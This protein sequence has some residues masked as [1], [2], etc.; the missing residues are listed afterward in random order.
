MA[1]DLHYYDGDCSTNETQT[2][3]KELFIKIINTSAFRQACQD[4]SFRD[5][6]KAENVVV[7]CGEVDE[8]VGNR[9]RRSTG[10]SWNSFS[11]ALL[12]FVLLY[13]VYLIIMHNNDEIVT[14]KGGLESLF[15]CTLLCQPYRKAKDHRGKLH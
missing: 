11:K 4:P 5:K 14:L 12:N 13:D 10:K 9:K 3:I 15:E 6:C 2:Q 7:T 1:M 8:S